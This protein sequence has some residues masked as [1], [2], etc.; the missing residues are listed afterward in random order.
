MIKRINLLG[1]IVTLAIYSFSIMTFISRLLGN[2][3][4]GS[5]FGYPLLLMALPLS[6]LLFKAPQLKRPVMY[7][8]QVSLM[9]A[10]LLVELVLDYILKADFRNTQWVVICYVMLFFGATGGMLGVASYANRKWKITAVILFFIMGILA[11][12]QRSV[13]GL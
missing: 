5:W 9:L 2:P 1:T 12:V 6:Y 3:E 7:Y 8:V 10:L 13:T 11:F 4:I